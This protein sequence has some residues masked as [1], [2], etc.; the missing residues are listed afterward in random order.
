MIGRPPQSDITTA[1][2]ITPAQQGADITL[3][4]DGDDSLSEVVKIDKEKIY[5]Q[6]QK[7]VLLPSIQEDN[8]I[9]STSTNGKRNFSIFFFFLLF[10]LNILTFF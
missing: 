7:N 9:S 10:G 4:H 6:D 1:S 8:S 2:A 3:I 5:L